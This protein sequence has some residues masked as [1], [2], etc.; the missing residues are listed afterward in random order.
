MLIMHF[1]SNRQQ[2]K[3]MLLKSRIVKFTVETPMIKFKEWNIFKGIPVDLR[4]YCTIL[5]NKEVTTS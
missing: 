3:I 1:L 2:R 4:S 5:S